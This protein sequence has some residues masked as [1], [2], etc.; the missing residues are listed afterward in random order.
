MGSKRV[1]ARGFTPK[2]HLPVFFLFFLVFSM[3]SV[4]PVQ[5]VG[6][7]TDNGDG[8]V[9]D[10]GTNFTWQ[11]SDDGHT[12]RWQEALEYCENLVLAGHDDW[13]LPNIR[14]L[15]SIV[16]YGF[17][18]AV[19]D[20]FSFS[21]SGNRE[22]W[23]STTRAY[24]EKTADGSY[25]CTYCDHAFAVN[26]YE[27]VTVT[28]D[29]DGSE[30]R[31][32]C[33]R[34]GG[35][36]QPGPDYSLVVDKNGDG[37]GTV[38]SIFEDTGSTDGRINCGDD[39][40][41]KY[42]SGDTVFLRAV[43]AHGFF[44]RWSGDCNGTGQFT[45][46]KMD[47][48]KHCT[49]TFELDCVQFS[50]N[51]YEVFESQGNATITVT[52]RGT[53]NPASVG[54]KM[55]YGTATAGSD[56]RSVSGFLYWGV[57]DNSDKIFY[58]P[59]IDDDRAEYDEFVMLE[60]YSPSFGIDVCTPSVATLKILDDDRDWDDLDSDGVPDGTEDAGPNGGDGNNDGILDSKQLNVASLPSATGR[61]YMTVVVSPVNPN[62]TC[63]EIQNL[64]AVTEAEPDQGYTYPYGLVRFEIPCSSAK[65][66]V[67]YHGT[68]EFG[69][70]T[71]RKYGPVPP[72]FDNPQWYTLPGA[73]F[74]KER[75]G[76]VDLSKVEFTLNDGE[77]GDDTGL[78]GVIYDE[79]GA[80]ETPAASSSPPPAPANLDASVVSGCQEGCV[81]DVKLSWNTARGAGGYLIYNADTGQLARWIKD[82]T[83]TSYTFHNLP[84]G[85]VFH[86]YIKT[87]SYTGNSQ[88][89]KTVAVE[90]PACSGPGGTGVAVNL[91]WPEKERAIN[92]D[93][94]DAANYLVVFAWN[95]VE[96]A[97]GYL[98]SLSLDD[99]SGDPLTGQAV[100]SS[101]NGLLEAGDLA[102]IYFV[103]DK[104]GW[105]SL[106]PYT[107]TWQVSA[108]SDPES[109]GSV[110]GT[111]T[112]DRFTLNPAP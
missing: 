95:R 65:V 90:I 33:V 91:V 105:N 14:E 97:G 11:K 12:Y 89:S 13:H 69:D 51:T 110:M 101:D 67:Y 81:A 102:G 106:A 1:L 8:T 99:G 16:R 103:L 86:F 92:Y 38:V 83:A 25:I 66:T 74:G 63:S 111:S 30:L 19:P 77:L 41:E 93:D 21:G 36:M 80:A 15:L 35:G 4:K 34:G 26:F 29:K 10:N 94:F 71:Y 9:T 100:L 40:E 75:V 61:G 55:T 70:L 96:K 18:P 17:Q 54:Y 64:R 82:G 85:Q 76:A 108:L 78:D 27:G 112:R 22:Y 84:C 7:Y 107:V 50:A 6:P 104:A 59:I 39:C 60:L 87:H 109:L 68:Y 46:V 31:A 58:V 24:L 56:Y 43:P 37:D 79:G 49:A 23:S 45:T 72:K 20:E 88:P 57:R 98:L 53:D 62:E 5:A 47:S 44:A 32:L 28:G 52:R 42:H 3:L 73:A 48:D 2:L